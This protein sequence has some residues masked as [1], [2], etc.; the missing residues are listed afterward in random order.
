MLL[1]LDVIAAGCRSESQRNR[2]QELGYCFE[3]FRRALEQAEQAAWHA[4]AAQYQRLV[5]E[6]VHAARRAAADEADP[7]ELAYEAL[8]RF[9]RTLTGR[10]NPLV[11]RFPHVGALLKYLQQCAVTTV[12]DQRRRAMRQARLAARVIDA[13]PTGGVSAGIEEHTVHR[14]DQAAL[15]ARI[16]A[17]V[18]TEVV[19]P[20]ERIVLQASYTDDLSPADI[21]AR[22][23][24]RFADAAAVRQIKERVLRRARRALLDGTSPDP[25]LSG[26]V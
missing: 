4:V 5:L 16:R 25:T 18:A 23:P 9:W 1:S 2:S 22:H 12:L 6:W 17:W 8:E 15:L 14:V 26:T 3:L 7:E 21:A 20:D 13:A 24:E 10:C 19:D 11:A